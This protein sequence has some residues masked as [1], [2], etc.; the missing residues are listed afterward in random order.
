LFHLKTPFFLFISKNLTTRFETFLTNR[1]IFISLNAL[2]NA[3]EH[4]LS[5]LKAIGVSKSGFK[6]TNSAY[7]Y[8]GNLYRIHIAATP[9]PTWTSYPKGKKIVGWIPNGIYKT[10]DS[11][12]VGYFT[13]GG[14]GVIDALNEDYTVSYIVFY[15]N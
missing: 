7:V 11:T 1:F 15:W 9:D 13:D 14:W 4:I 10:A 3:Y 2:Y 6:Q 12:Y 8:S 5:S